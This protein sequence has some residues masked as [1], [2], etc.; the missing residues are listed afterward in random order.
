M[1]IKQAL[2]YPSLSVLLLA[3]VGFVIS[4]ATLAAGLQA[5]LDRTHIIE[6]E[7]VMLRLSQ[8]GHQGVAPDLSPLEQDFEILDRSQSTRTQIINGYMTTAHEWQLILAPKRAGNLQ[9]PAIQAGQLQSPALALTVTPAQEVAQTGAHLPVAL[10]V[11]ASPLTPYVQ[12][13]LIYKTRLWVSVPM[14]RTNLGDPEGHGLVI[15]PLGD[16]NRRK[17]RRGGKEYLVVERSYAIFPQQSGPLEI[18]GPVFTGE[19]AQTDKKRRSGSLFG[20]RDPFARIDQLLGGGSLAQRNRMFYMRGR[21]ISIDVQPQ[22]AG[23]SRPWLPADAVTLE[24]GWS[25]NL[26]Q[27]RVGEPLT[28]SVTLNARGVTGTQLPDLTFESVPGVAIYQDKSQVNTRVT[29]SGLLARKVFKAAYVPSW[30]GRHELPE[31]KLPWWDTQTNQQRIATIPARSIEVLPAAGSVAQTPQTPHQ[32]VPQPTASSTGPVMEGQPMNESTADE[33]SGPMWQDRALDRLHSIGE[34]I[35]GAGY[36]PWLAALFAFAWLITL[37]L[38]WRHRRDSKDEG[39]KEPPKRVSVNPGAAMRKVQKACTANDPQAARKH[40]LVWAAATW[41]DDAPRGLDE[42]AQRLPGSAREQLA[43]LDR[44]LY[45]PG[46]QAWDAG[47]FW[48][49]LAPVM[50]E[51]AVAA[52]SDVASPLPPLYSGS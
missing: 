38:L 20:S 8:P 39:E 14:T 51:G 52:Q 50:R 10:E 41:P 40:L 48:Q 11:D 17:L 30:A 43:A 26:G 18:K 24:E 5:S 44:E 36:W 32:Q 6:G 13:K 23:S 12:G 21:D 34:R 19:L 3:L 7:T 31:I 9:V 28:R 49:T 1:S 25:L 46:Q 47:R 37:M 27:A 4:S 15:E 22:P 2:P 33:R 29:G 35:T 42:L 45:S 16:F